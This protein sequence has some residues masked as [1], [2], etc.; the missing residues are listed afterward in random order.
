MEHVVLVIHFNDMMKANGGALYQAVSDNKFYKSM[1]GVLTVLYTDIQVLMDEH[2][3]LIHVP[4]T[5]TL[6]QMED[7]LCAQHIQNR[8]VMVNSVKQ[9]IAMLVRL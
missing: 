3:Y 2:V 8:K 7:V 4:A 9:I 6:T 5:T 1:V